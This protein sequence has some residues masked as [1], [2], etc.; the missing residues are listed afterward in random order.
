M[1]GFTGIKLVMLCIVSLSIGMG[2]T[3]LTSI[4]LPSVA[5]MAHLFGAKISTG[6]IL[7]ILMIGDMI[8]VALYVK[9]IKLKDV[10]KFIQPAIIGIFLGTFLGHYINDTQFRFIMSIMILI[11]VAFLIQKE[12]KNQNQEIIIPK[13]NKFL[14]ISAGILSGFSSM[15]GNVAGPFFAVYLLSMQYK[16]NQFIGTTVLFFFFINW[17]K[18]PFHIFWWKTITWDTLK[19]V[20]LIIPI[21]LAGALLGFYIVKR[22]NEKRYRI[23]IIVMTTIAALYLMF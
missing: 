18:F 16:K 11:C 15:V 4:N 13:Q 5:I 10:L 23:F 1:L 17:I 3:G 14:Y 9:Y 2:K 19:I 7:P 22:I 20:P 12:I 6:I 21:V 8:G